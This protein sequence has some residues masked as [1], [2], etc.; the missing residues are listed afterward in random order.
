MSDKRIED[1]STDE[2]L[3][4]LVRTQREKIEG[5]LNAQKETMENVFSAQKETME[6]MFSAQKGAFKEKMGPAKEKFDDTMKGFV[7][8]IMNPEIQKHFVRS[9]IEFL[10]GI[11]EMIK[12]VPMPEFMK[13]NVEKACDAKDEVVKD[14]AKEFVKDD[15][16][17]TTNKKMKKID[18]E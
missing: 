4:F 10:S 8:M 5:M 17:K 6:N 1:M 13:E 15:G 9:G 18:V 2:I 7:S 11:E 12:N 14:M 16:P 3:E